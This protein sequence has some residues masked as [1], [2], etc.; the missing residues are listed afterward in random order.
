MTNAAPSGPGPELLYRR[1]REAGIDRTLHERL[2]FFVVNRWEMVPDIHFDDGLDTL[3]DDAQAYRALRLPGSE[4][5][6]GHVAS[7]SRADRGE[8]AFLM[9]ELGVRKAVLRRDFPEADAL[10]LNAIGAVYATRLKGRP[11]TSR[12]IFRYVSKAVQA[13]V[14]LDC[15]VRRRA[16]DA[17]DAALFCECFTHAYAA[18]RYLSEGFADVLCPSEAWV[19]TESALSGRL[20]FKLCARSRQPYFKHECFVGRGFSPFLNFKHSR[21]SAADRSL[22]HLLDR[23]GYVKRQ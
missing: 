13:N 18:Y 17:F 8:L 22:M 11:A 5:L 6:G 7:M 23:G 2:R 9:A 3:V 20:R 21:P 10:T 1:C 4:T 16:Y 14:F 12:R 15:F 19:V